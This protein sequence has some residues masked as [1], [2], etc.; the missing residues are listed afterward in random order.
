MRANGKQAENVTAA[1]KTSR[2]I[3]GPWLNDSEI[4]ERRD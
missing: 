4:E 2:N 3:R 1:A